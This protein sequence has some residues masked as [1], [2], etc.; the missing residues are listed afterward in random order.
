MEVLQCR[1][2]RRRK[3]RVKM[4]VCQTVIKLFCILLL[5]SGISSSTVG[6]AHSS[7]SLIAFYLCLCSN[8][9]NSS[10]FLA[11]ST[12]PLNVG[13]S[14]SHLQ[15]WVTPKMQTNPNCTAVT[16]GKL[17]FYYCNPEVC[18]FVMEVIVL[19]PV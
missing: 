11:P 16:K 15:Y 6:L 12:L 19:G 14:L 13:F 10:L 7:L 8:L 2:A 9:E 17:Q 5:L 4:V 18:D 3:K 1:L